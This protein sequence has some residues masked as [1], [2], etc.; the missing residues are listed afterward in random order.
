M[1]IFAL[2]SMLFIGAIHLCAQNELM[3]QASDLQDKVLQD[4]G[5]TSEA[6]IA[7]TPYVNE[8]NTEGSFYLSNK[9]VIKSL[10]RLNCY[11]GN[12]EFVSKG[13]IHLVN[14]A[15]IDSVKLDGSVYVY[16]SF[17]PDGQNQ[18]KAVKVIERKGSNG[19]YEY[20]Q[21][22]YKPEVK[23]GGFIDPKPACFEWVDPVY[24]LEVKDKIVV[25]K[26]VKS[27]TDLFPKNEEA[28]KKYIKENRINF[29]KPDKLKRLLDYI[30]QL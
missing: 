23:A 11:Y 17:S 9:T 10:T 16:R 24:L 3:L 26:N 21:V 7:G 5:F 22:E 12:F 4:R 25:L 29:N 13:K 18:P 19:I 20:R 15:G 30:S 2:I 27:V 6:G 1:K 8:T 28:I 14:T